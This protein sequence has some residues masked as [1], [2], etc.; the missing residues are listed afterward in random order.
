MAD[1]PGKGAARGWSRLSSTVLFDSEWL[2]LRRDRAVRPDGSQGEYHHVVVPESVT[3]LAVADDG[4]LAVTRQWI[5]VHRATQWRLPSGRVESSDS[6]PESAARRELREETGVFAERLVVLGTINC[7]DSF[8][9][10]REHAFLAIGLHHGGARLEAGEADLEVHWL[11]FERVL[12]LVTTGQ[13]PHAGSCFAVL[14]AYTLGMVG[15]SS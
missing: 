1:E 11:P 14:N 6:G 13:L 5:Y 3:V 8:S 10:H 15:N 4:R 2:Q 12:S 7:A 9:N